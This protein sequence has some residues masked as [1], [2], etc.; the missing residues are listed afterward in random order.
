[1]E[2]QVKK[3]IGEASLKLVLVSALF[4]AALFIFGFLVD[5]V[6]YENEDLFDSRVFHF[7][8][9][10]SS[11]AFINAMHFLTFFGSTYFFF[12][13]YLLMILYFIIVR[14]K[15]YALDI[16]IVGAS[17]TLLM[18]GLK[19][20]FHRKRPDLPLFKALTNYSFPSGHALSSFIFCSMLIY[21]IWNGK[22]QQSA[23]WIASV[24]LLL[25]SISIGI[26]RIVLRYH[27]AS[28]VVAGFCLGFVWSILSLWILKKISAKRLHNKNAQQ[29]VTA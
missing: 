18:L 28:D 9:Q 6:V 25:F 14:K 27:F 5:E 22:W 10:F 19:N 11:P 3:K 23:K 2:E 29:A 12:P 15:N 7:F 13:A 21:I 17:S 26:S 16:F 4:I 24:L 8:A 1:M 20:I